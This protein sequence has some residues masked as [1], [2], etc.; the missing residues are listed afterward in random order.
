MN[1]LQRLWEYVTLG[2]ISFVVE[3]AAPL[4]GGVKAFDRNLHLTGVIV[5]V[6]IGTWVVGVALYALGR[7]QGDR[8]RKGW[9][10]LRPLVLQAAAI[11]RR[12]PW[13]AAL[14]VRFAFGLRVPL[15]IACG[16]ARLPLWL[17]VT[18][19]AVRTVLRSRNVADCR[20][21][22]ARSNSRKSAS[23]DASSDGDVADS[24]WS[25]AIPA[26]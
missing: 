15:P 26:L 25:T 14:G 13:R 21:A 8:L 4:F 7:W 22:R 5:A 12:H 24:P 2:A 23:P 6:A 17:F 9:P 1:F 11:V 3:E 18:A 19:S 20:R 10:K 16:V